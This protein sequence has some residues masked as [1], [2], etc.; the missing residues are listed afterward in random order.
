MSKHTG[1]RR[2]SGV[3]LFSCLQNAWTPTKHQDNWKH[4]H[5]L[6]FSPNPHKFTQQLY[7]GS[8]LFRCFRPLIHL[9]MNCVIVQRAC[10]NMSLKFHFTAGIFIPRRRR[11][12]IGLSMSVRPSFRPSVRSHNYVTAERNYMKFILN[13]SHYNDVMSSLVRLALVAPEL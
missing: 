11:R 6:P 3:E 4:L 10:I 9:A 12:D 8:V 7:K 13:M 2:I 1:W 5:I